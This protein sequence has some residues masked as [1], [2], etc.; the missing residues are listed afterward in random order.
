MREEE[1]P[2]TPASSNGNGAKSTP[3]SP[4]DLGDIKNYYP[5]TPDRV[6][7]SPRY[8]KAPFFD[9]KSSKLN[10]N[11]SLLHHTL[12][13]RLGGIVPTPDQYARLI[14]QSLLLLKC[15]PD[16]LGA[17]LMAKFL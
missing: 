8:K 3:P 13:N 11:P 17:S 6:P 12:T 14:E 1:R 4:L 16:D 7:Q 2:V 9:S 5:V 10:S 15:L